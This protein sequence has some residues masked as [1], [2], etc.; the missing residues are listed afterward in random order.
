MQVYIYPSAIYLSAIYPS[1]IY[2]YT[3]GHIALFGV[4]LCGSHEEES[5]S[6]HVRWVV[7][8]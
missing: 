7:L 1:A 2:L 5:Y 3:R 4:R 8:R 6:V